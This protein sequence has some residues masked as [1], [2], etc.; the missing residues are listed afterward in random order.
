MMRVSE[1]LKSQLQPAGAALSMN[2]NTH[3]F[4]SP[5][6]ANIKINSPEGC[7]R[8]FSMIYSHNNS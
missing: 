1:W 3:R 5:L 6:L 2:L 8:D 4:A 7:R